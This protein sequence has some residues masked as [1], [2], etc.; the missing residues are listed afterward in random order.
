MR[1]ET[2]C[3][4][5]VYGT[6]ITT[7][8]SFARISNSNQFRHTS[9]TTPQTGPRILRICDTIATV[10]LSR[11]VIGLALAA[12]P[13]VSLAQ[14]AGT[15]SVAGSGETLEMRLSILAEGAAAP[16]AF[17]LSQ[18]TRT[19]WT[20]EV[21]RYEE[22]KAELRV[23]CSDE[24]RKANRDTITAKAGQCLR[25]DLLLEIGYRRKQREMVVTVPGAT[26][27]PTHAMDDW[28]DAASAVV[29]GIDTGIFTTVDIL[30]QAKRNLHLTYRVPMLVALTQARASSVDAM[31]GSLAGVAQELAATLEDP[32]LFMT[33]IVACL[34]D[35]H[36]AARAAQ[37]ATTLDE[38]TSELQLS[39]GRVQVCLAILRGD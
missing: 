34:D 29:D 3:L 39:M 33:S 25:A 31:V 7:I 19:A 2:L 16:D 23:R 5:L 6:A 14:D 24:I 18:N 37:A 27:D 10:H 21:K 22:R 12:L 17:A 38:A 11:F 1:V 13:A 30:K 8:A 32:A 26:I 20:A 35:A 28:I 36:T 9:A 15:G 4:V